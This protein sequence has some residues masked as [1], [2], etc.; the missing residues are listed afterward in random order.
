MGSE[1]RGLK[2][3]ALHQQFED[4][5][6]KNAGMDIENM[7]MCKGFCSFFNILE[8]YWLLN[9]VV[10][11][12]IS[13]RVSDL[14]DFYI[15]SKREPSLR[16]KHTMGIKQSCSIFGDLCSHPQ[17]MDIQRCFESGTLKKCAQN[18]IKILL[19]NIH[20]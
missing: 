19:W 4:F 12:T 5:V 3:L 16:V 2:F 15:V 10:L 18:G 11:S 7:C 6:V 14:Y 17:V 13:Q 20:S 1:H 9:L 8:N